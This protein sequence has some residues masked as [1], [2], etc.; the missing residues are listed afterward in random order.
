MESLL[1]IGIN[2]FFDRILVSEI[3][4]RLK[5]CRLRMSNATVAITFRDISIKNVFTS[6]CNHHRPVINLIRPLHQPEYLYSDL[7]VFKS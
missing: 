6:E 7:M 3:V 5:V 4:S 2:R 1:E